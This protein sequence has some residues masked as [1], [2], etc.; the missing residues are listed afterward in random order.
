MDGL[1]RPSLRWVG[2]SPKRLALGCSPLHLEGRESVQRQHK[3]RAVTA[4]SDA[5]LERFRAVKS[6]GLKS[7]ML[8]R[9][10]FKNIDKLTFLVKKV[11]CGWWFVGLDIS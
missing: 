6:T 1:R 8:M 5:R 11:G 3:T 4:I 2:G 7:Q 10:C 9:I